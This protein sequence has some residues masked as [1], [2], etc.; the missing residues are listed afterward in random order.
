MR[1]GL[2]AGALAVAVVLLLEPSAFA[3]RAEVTRARQLYEDLH[4]GQAE[5]AFEAA[6]ALEGNGPDDLAAIEL[7]LGLLAGARNDEAAAE[8]HFRR[9]LEV[10]PDIALPAGLPP[11]ITRPFERARAFWGDGRLG[12]AHEPADRWAVGG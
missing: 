10:A 3:E 5:R 11:K 7:H 9:A 2:Q 6:L 8:E 1:R 12:V 4:Y